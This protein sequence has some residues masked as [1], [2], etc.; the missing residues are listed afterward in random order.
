MEYCQ[1]NWMNSKNPR[2]FSILQIMHYMV[3]HVATKN[4]RLANCHMAALIQALISLMC[5][6]SVRWRFGLFAIFH[7]RRFSNSIVAESNDSISTDTNR[8]AFH[9][10]RDQDYN[11]YYTNQLLFF[12]KNFL[13]WIMSSIAFCILLNLKIRIWDKNSNSKWI[14][15]YN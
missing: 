11:C 7:R 2:K 5:I 12:Q 13:F 14:Y 15:E 9:W 3:L 1:H 6:R 4:N 8:L 10:V